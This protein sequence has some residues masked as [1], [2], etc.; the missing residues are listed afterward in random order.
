MNVRPKP[1]H[2]NITTTMGFPHHFITSE[3]TDGLSITLLESDKDRVIHLLEKVKKT[4][5]SNSN[6]RLKGFTF[7][8]SAKTPITNCNISSI[9][10]ADSNNF[11]VYRNTKSS[12]IQRI[13]SIESF[14]KADLSFLSSSGLTKNQLNQIFQIQAKLQKCNNQILMQDEISILQ[15][16]FPINIKELALDSRRISEN[17]HPQAKTGRNTSSSVI[18]TKLNNKSVV[19]NQHKSVE[20]S[21]HAAKSMVHTVQDHLRIDNI[22]AKRFRERDKLNIQVNE[23]L[24]GRMKSPSCTHSV[25]YSSCLYQKRSMNLTRKESKR[26]VF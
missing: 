1:K 23:F 9:K 21:N 4:H 17:K 14:I 18:S 12:A 13:G 11:S 7:I 2:Q 10:K 8:N 22:I 5:L 20:M 3:G 6:D 26:A 24:K 15:Q 19:I 25:R 16:L